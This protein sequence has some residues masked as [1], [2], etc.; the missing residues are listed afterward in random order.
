MQCDMDAD[1][2]IG[3][4]CS[5]GTDWCIFCF[6][7]FFFND[8]A[9]TEIYTL[10]IV[11]SVRCVQETVSTQSTWAIQIAAGSQTIWTAYLLPQRVISEDCYLEI[12]SIRRIGTIAFS[13]ISLSTFISGVSLS[14]QLY[15]FSIVFSFMKLH[16]LHPH[17][18]LSSGGAGMKVLFGH[19]FVNS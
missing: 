17:V 19:R 10:H 1:F 7:F 3:I 13:A 15:T 9:T 6:F 11:G 5:L 16:S 4:T 12:S 18:W 2:V 14:R 8:T